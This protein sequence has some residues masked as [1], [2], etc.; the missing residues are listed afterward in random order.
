LAPWP[1]SGFGYRKLN[2]VSSRRVLS[3]TVALALMT[4]TVL[5]IVAPQAEAV[6]GNCSS[7]RQEKDDT[8]YNSYRVR[9]RCSSLNADSKAKGVLDKSGASDPETTWFTQLNTYKYSNYTTCDIFNTCNNTR[10][11]IAHV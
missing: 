2:I 3:H 5:A 6:G 10:V 1:C 8:G 4:G 11:D 9:A 7:V